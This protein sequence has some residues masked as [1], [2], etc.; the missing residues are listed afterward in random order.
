MGGRGRKTQA[1]EF[2]FSWKD[3]HEEAESFTELLELRKE[4]KHYISAISVIVSLLTLLTQAFTMSAPSGDGS[5]E[6]LM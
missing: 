5:V 4:N 1:D 6:N 3:K 2:R